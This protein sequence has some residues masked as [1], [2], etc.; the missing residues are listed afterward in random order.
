MPLDKK[1]TEKPRMAGKVVD[2]GGE[3]VFQEVWTG[4]V[5]AFLEL[6]PGVAGH[7]YKAIVGKMIVL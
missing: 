6:V 3:T 1:L 7:I 5:K 4:G 2:E